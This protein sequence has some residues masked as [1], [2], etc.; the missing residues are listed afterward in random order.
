MI[1]AVWLSEALVMD[2][3]RLGKYRKGGSLDSPFIELV[4]E[5]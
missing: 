1:T 3:A 4:L 2:P 5:N